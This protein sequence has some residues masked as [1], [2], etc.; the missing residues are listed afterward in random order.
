MSKSFDKMIFFMYYVFIEHAPQVKLT[1]PRISPSGCGRYG[2]EAEKV[3][4][5][6]EHV[7]VD[8]DVIDI[9]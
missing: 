3:E 4:K 1:Y 2:G 8:A 6:R 7:L 5:S 9:H